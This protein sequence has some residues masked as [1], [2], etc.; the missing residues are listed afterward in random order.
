[1]NELQRKIKERDGRIKKLEALLQENNILPSSMT[2]EDSGVD[3]ASLQ[4]N[5]SDLESQVQDLSDQLKQ[6]STAGPMDDLIKDLQAN[7]RKKTDS[8]AKFE[9]EVKKLR[10]D[11]ANAGKESQEKD[12]I[13][14]KL[15][16]ALNE[17][18]HP[19]L[20]PNERWLY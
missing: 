19:H 2:T 15:K 20:N 11:L 12:E 5:I 8:I 4:Q 9:A 10:D 1:V 17:I 13:I 18:S 6:K 7:L 16:D 14:A 3:I